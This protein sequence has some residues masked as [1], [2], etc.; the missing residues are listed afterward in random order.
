MKAKILKLQ[1]KDGESVLIK[2]DSKT[3]LIIN[4]SKSI[5]KMPKIGPI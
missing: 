2:K 4:H 3:K 5:L 1:L